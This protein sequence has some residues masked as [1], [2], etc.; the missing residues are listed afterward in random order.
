[1]F[2]SHYML[3]EMALQSRSFRFTLSSPFFL[4]LLRVQNTTRSTPYVAAEGNASPVD[5]KGI[6]VKDQGRLELHGQESRLI[7][8]QHDTRKHLFFRALNYRLDRGETRACF[9]HWS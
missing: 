9:F 6:F 5:T 8:T 7:H 4:L 3:R 2:A 1:M